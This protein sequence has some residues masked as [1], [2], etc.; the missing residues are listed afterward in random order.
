MIIDKVKPLFSTNTSFNCF[1]F[2]CRNCPKAS[3]LGGGVLGLVGLAMARFPAAAGFVDGGL[4]V[5]SC[6]CLTFSAGEGDLFTSAKTLSVLPLR[7][8]V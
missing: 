2:S 4:S 3:C 5:W 8:F 7:L 6:N 1:P